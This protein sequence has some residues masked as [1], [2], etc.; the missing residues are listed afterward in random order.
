[1]I[2]KNNTVYFLRVYIEIFLQIK[3]I[4]TFKIYIIQNKGMPHGTK[5]TL[6]SIH[7]D[8][9]SNTHHIKTLSLNMQSIQNPSQKFGAIITG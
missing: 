3:V 4:I 5:M 7:T 8:N 6:Q 9:Q 1:M 2:T